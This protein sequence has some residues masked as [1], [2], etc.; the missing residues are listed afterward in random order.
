ME[1]KETHKKAEEIVNDAWFASI[2]TQAKKS[3]ATIIKS[4]PGLAIFFGTKK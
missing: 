2:A 3:G 4:L 1:K